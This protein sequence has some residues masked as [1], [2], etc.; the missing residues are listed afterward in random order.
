[1]RV[2]PLELFIQC[3]VTGTCS[4]ATIWD[5]ARSK[6]CCDAEARR[7]AVQLHP[8]VLDHL[9]VV[10]WGNFHFKKEAKIKMKKFFFLLVK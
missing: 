2:W 4:D 1:M 9:V 3:A 7:E 6:A 8:S 10:H 5:A